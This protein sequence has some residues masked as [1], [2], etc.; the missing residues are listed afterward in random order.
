M[1][2][3]PAMT[4]I[5]AFRNWTPTLVCILD[6]RHGHHQFVAEKCMTDSLKGAGHEYINVRFAP[7]T[8]KRMV[9]I[10]VD[11]RVAATHAS[12]AGW[13]NDLLSL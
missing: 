4:L 9:S 1:M 6:G 7:L 8:A 13:S 11:K 5:F 3:R 10:L 2:M 12:A